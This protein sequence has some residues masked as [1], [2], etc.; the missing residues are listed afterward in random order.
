MM[1]RRLLFLLAALVAAAPLA[2]AEGEIRVGF[3]GPLTGP[4][5]RP[6]PAAA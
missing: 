4:L 6:A 5:P 1:L 3:A 2:H